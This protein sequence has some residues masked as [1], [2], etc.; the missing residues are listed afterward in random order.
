[1][2]TYS[3]DRKSICLGERK[4]G[5]GPR[6]EERVYDDPSILLAIKVGGVRVSF[7]TFS[8]YTYN[9]GLSTQLAMYCPTTNKQT[10][11]IT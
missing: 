8:L 3:Y 7:C 5:G 6:D 4:G 2:V 10:K 11:Q 1:M 9:F